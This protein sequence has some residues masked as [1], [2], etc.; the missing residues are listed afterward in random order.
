MDDRVKLLQWWADYI[1][2][3]RTGKLLKMRKRAA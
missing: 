2:G 3:R 1:D